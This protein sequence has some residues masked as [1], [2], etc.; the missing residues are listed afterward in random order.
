MRNISFLP[1]KLENW[2]RVW[3]ERGFFSDCRKE[4]KSP[5]LRG[6]DYFDFL[7]RRREKREEMEGGRQEVL[8]YLL[9]LGNFAVKDLNS[10]NVGGEI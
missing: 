5:D 8:I 6:R 3:S 10:I 4:E 9:N 7:E 1:P 2:G